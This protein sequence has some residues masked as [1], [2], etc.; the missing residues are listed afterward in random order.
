[1]KDIKDKLQIVLHYQE[2]KRKE[3]QILAEVVYPPHLIVK[4][5]DQA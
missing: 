3:I 4:F 2:N 1:M 5:K